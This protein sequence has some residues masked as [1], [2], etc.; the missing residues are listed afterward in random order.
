[1]DISAVNAATSAYGVAN[2]SSKVTSSNQS[3]N[4]AQTIQ[5]DSINLS[6]EAIAA[7]RQEKYALKDDPIELF[8]EWLE[9]D[10]PR[11]ISFTGIKPYGEM[12]PETQSYIDQLNQRLEQAQTPE[13]RKQIEAY[14]SGAS[15][16]GSHEMIQS[17]S[18][19]ETRWQVEQVSVD[20]M[21]AHSQINNEEIGLSDYLMD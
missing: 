21:M 10:N 5:A 14:I 8:N 6:P 2:Q 4:V 13:Q 17:D 15:R 16:F 9:N 20:L 12:L 3:G 7:Q 19:L 18:D 1:M 11:T